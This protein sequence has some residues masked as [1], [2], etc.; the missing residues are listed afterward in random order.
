MCEF[1][2]RSVVG[3]LVTD[4]IKLE[5]TL[6]S[7]TCYF[8]TGRCVYSMTDVKTRQY[9]YD[10]VLWLWYL[11]R[12]DWVQFFYVFFNY[13]FGVQSRRYKRIL[14]TSY[15]QVC[16]LILFLWR[17]Q[18]YGFH[19][20]LYFSTFTWILIAYYL[21]II[22]KKVVCFWWQRSGG[23]GGSAHMLLVAALKRQYRYCTFVFNFNLTSTL[24]KHILKRLFGNQN[25]NIRLIYGEKCVVKFV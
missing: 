2:S 11:F 18:V 23:F 15:V 7:E 16:F 9:R 20:R 24:F 13:L 19:N 25:V 6:T 3:F 12:W 4:V 21:N 22:S 10:Y 8:P 17:D 14:L 5:V 1:Y